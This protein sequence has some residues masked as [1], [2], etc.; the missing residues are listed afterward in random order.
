[1]RKQKR[2]LLKGKIPKTRN[3]VARALC[4]D[5]RFQTKTFKNK[6][7]ILKKYNWKKEDLE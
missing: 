3:P 7:K 4:T 6:K 1:M 2:I 5:S